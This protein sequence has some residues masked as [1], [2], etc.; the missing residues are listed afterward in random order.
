M[1][2]LFFCDGLVSFDA[3]REDAAKLGIGV[4]ETNFPFVRANLHG[5][6]ENFHEAFSGNYDAFEVVLGES[7]PLEI[8]T[9][10]EQAPLILKYLKPLGEFESKA[11]ESPAYVEG[12]VAIYVPLDRVVAVLY[13]LEETSF[14]VD[15]GL[16]K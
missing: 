3:I 13:S 15:Y 1:Q 11:L 4:L 8:V 5:S 6:L 16:E 9:I 12:S 7:K 10:A 14:S 2:V